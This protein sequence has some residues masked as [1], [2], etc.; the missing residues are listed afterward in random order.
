[1]NSHQQDNLR[2]SEEHKLWLFDLSHGN[3][4]DYEVLSGWLK[5]Y[6]LNG[7]TIGNVQDDIVFHTMYG[8]EGAMTAMTKLKSVI[9]L[10]ASGDKKI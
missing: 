2:Y 8:T 5:Y 4:M 6:A 1:M 3:L 7:C 9:T 10:V